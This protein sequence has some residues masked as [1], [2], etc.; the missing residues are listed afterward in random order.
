MASPLLGDKYTPQKSQLSELLKAV[1][2]LALD[3]KSEEVAK[4]ITTLVGNLS[5]PFLF[6]VIGEVKAGKSSFINALLGETVCAVAAKPCTAVIEKIVYG[7]QITETKINPQLTQKTAPAEILRSISIVDTPG[8]NTI[9]AQH[10][11]ITEG[12]IPN[13]DLAIFVFYAANPYTETAW[14]LLDYVKGEWRKRVIFVLQQRDR[15]TPEELETN[16][17]EVRAQLARLQIVDPQIF[18]TSARWENEGR[19]DIS[20]FGPVRDY[21][22]ETITEGNPARLKLQSVHGTA[23]RQVERLRTLLA[24]ETAQ[25]LR[26]RE[27]VD[28]IK[29]RLVHNEKQS[30]REIQAL[31]DGVMRGYEEICRDLADEFEEG[32]SFGALISRSLRSLLGRESS[33]DRWI[34][35]MQQR[36][37]QRVNSVVDEIARERARTFVDSVRKLLEEMRGEV[38][39]VSRTG[40]TQRPHLSLLEDKRVEVLEDVRKRVTLLL[41]DDSFTRLLEENPGGIVPLAASGSALALVGGVIALSTNLVVLD[42]TG[43]LLSAAG[44]TVAGG[45]LFWKRARIVRDFSQG[46]ERGKKQFE[47]DI[48]V[49]LVDKLKIIY[50]QID[51]SFFEFY[52]LVET[53]TKE[54]KAPQ[55]RLAHI[56]QEYK[57]LAADLAKS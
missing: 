23:G 28:K 38:E 21:I 57:T 8:T 13:S 47:Q 32:L 29:S 2:A 26:D 37:K 54:L 33:V 10:E 36:F 22:R 30:G 40:A 19:T 46:L 16:V 34:A 45:M 24:D 56:E 52:D 3:L 15:A 1:H 7:P 11:E 53:R 27:L 9:I 18:V 31:I 35:E 14:K 41:Q 4:H 6:V 44:L 25:L 17:G 20:G 39:L 42:I 50:E 51:K 48:R 49:K 43:G 5:D 55:E 12:F